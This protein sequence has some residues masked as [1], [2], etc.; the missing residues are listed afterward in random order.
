VAQVDT[1]FPEDQ[2]AMAQGIL[3][4]V[5]SGFGYGLGCVISGVIY[6]Q[7]GC[8]CLLGASA[9]ISLLGLGIFFLGRSNQV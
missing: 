3:A 1:F 4:A 2:R 5:F 7:Y 6:D 8:T 9:G